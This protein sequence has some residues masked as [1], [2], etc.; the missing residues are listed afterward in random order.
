MQRRRQAF[1]RHSSW[2][3]RRDKLALAQQMR[4]QPTRAEAQLWSRLRGRQ[5]DGLKF[6]RQHIIAGY[7]ADFYCPAIQLVVEV[8]GPHHQ[9]QQPQDEFRTEVLGECGVRVIRVSA[10]AVMNNLDEV[11]RYIRRVIADDAA[12]LDDCMSMLRR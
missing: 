11:I 8:D 1:G 3:A 10:E 5:L 7:I 12:Q 9:C 6:R 2:F 4:R